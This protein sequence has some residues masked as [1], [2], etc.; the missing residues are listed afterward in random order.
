MQQ[1][2]VAL[3]MQSKQADTEL[4]QAQA[5]KAVADAEQSEANALKAKFEAMQ[6][7]QGGDDEAANR[8]QIEGYNAITNR[9]KVVGA[10]TPDSPPS[11]EEHLAPIVAQLVGEAL[12]QH[13]GIGADQGPQEGLAA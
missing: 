10:V 7:A 11:L 5:R 12:K 8:L 3:E 13:F 9:L 6:L 4:K 1:M 2:G